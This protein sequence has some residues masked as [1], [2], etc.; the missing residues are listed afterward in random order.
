MNNCGFTEIE[1]K[2]IEANYHKL[3]TVSDAW[4][5]S[6]IE[7]AKIDGYITM[8]FGTRIRTPLLA[9]TV[10]KTKMPFSAKSEG[11]SAGNAATQSYCALTL[12]AMNEFRKRVWASEYKYEILLSATVYDSIYLLTKNSA[13]RVKWVNDNLIDCMRWNKLPELQHDIIKI[14]SGVEIYWPSWAN[15]IDI[16]NGATEEEIKSICAEAQK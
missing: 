1:A 8:A 3:Y 16:P 9:K 10:G 11:R 6:I 5:E 4:M 15:A 7:K 13:K 12:R 14:S 2:A